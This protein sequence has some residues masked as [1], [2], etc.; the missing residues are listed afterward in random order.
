MLRGVEEVD[1][2]A[3]AGEADGP[4]EAADGGLQAEAVIVVWAR[5]GVHEDR[6]GDHRWGDDVVRVW[7]DTMC[8]NNIYLSTDTISRAAREAQ[9][10]P[11]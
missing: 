11:K 4:L 1:P 10:R 5:G 9:N 2:G 6:G 3:A 7:V 8:H